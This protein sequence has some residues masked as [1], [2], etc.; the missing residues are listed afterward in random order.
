[1]IAKRQKMKVN[2][3]ASSLAVLYFSFFVAFN[4][5]HFLLHEHASQDK[6]F[7]AVP[8]ASNLHSGEFALSDCSICQLLLSVQ[9]RSISPEI[10]FDY[11]GQVSTK[12]N[13]G[14]SIWSSVLSIV[15]IQPRAPPLRIV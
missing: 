11:V 6:I 14:K 3:A 5:H 8:G 9:E 1:M 15:H 13:G 4:L 10:A 12:I 7:R 2:L